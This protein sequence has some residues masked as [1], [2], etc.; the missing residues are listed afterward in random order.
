M[1][2]IENFRLRKTK[3]KDELLEFLQ[4]KIEPLSQEQVK[5]LC[6]YI[7]LSFGEGGASMLLIKVLTERINASFGLDFIPRSQKDV[8]LW[9]DKLWEKTTEPVQ[10]TML[11]TAVFDVYQH[12]V[13]SYSDLINK[14]EGLFKDLHKTPEFVRLGVKKNGQS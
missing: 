9:L 6:R 12:S 14:I 2:L 10:K 13:L 1:G 8:D 7:F 11:I 5:K 4:T 3:E